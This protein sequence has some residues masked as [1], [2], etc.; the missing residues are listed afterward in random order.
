MFILTVLLGRSSGAD[1]LGALSLLLA[2]AAL[3]QAVSVGGLAGAAVHRLL[4]AGPNVEASIISLISSRLVLILPT[5]VVG[6]LVSAGT[7]IIDDPVALAVFFSGY[8]IG[9]FDVGELGKSAKGHF[10]SMGIA[11]TLVVLVVAIPK[12]YAASD[13]DLPRVLIWQGVEAALWQIAVLPRSGFLLRLIPAAFRE[14]RSGIEQIWSLRSLWLGNVM[15]SLAQRIDLFIVGA[16]IGQTD[17]GQYSTA[18]RPVEASVILATSL[19][20]VLFNGLVRSSGSPSSYA[21][22]ARRNGRLIGLLG[23]GMTLFLALAGPFLI[24]W[25]YGSEFSI[26]AG[27]LPIYAISTFFVFQRQ[28]LSRLII[29]E[30]AY[31]VSLVN[32]LTMLCC[33]AG[34]NLVLIPVFGVLGAALAAAVAHPLSLGISMATTKQGRRLLC[35]AFGGLMLSKRTV[36][37]TAYR[38]IS[39]RQ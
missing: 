21:R 10:F 20:T 18:S 24:E 3:M 28:F 38:A 11:R 5:F 7:G 12:F 23:L 32:N 1:D 2:G 13:G 15:S 9:T 29:I 16:L 25:L 14:Y 30:K 17:V 39:E 6:G 36:R 35:L 4:T 26:A 31:N 27:L 22:S 19:V 37:L 34:L 33:S 8:A